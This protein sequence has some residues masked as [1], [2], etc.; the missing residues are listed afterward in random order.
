LVTVG[1]KH[2]RRG[3]VPNWEGPL[4]KLAGWL[5]RRR[6]PFPSAA[7]AQVW[8][9]WRCTGNSLPIMTGLVLPF[10]LLFLALGKNDVL[11][12]AQTL[13]S[14]LAVPV[15]LAG[16]VGVTRR[17]KNPWVK[18]ANGLAPFTAT[19]PLT[20]AALA[21]ARLK[22]AALS[23]LVAWALVVVAVPVAVLL[24]GNL[25]EVAGWWR[26]GLDRASPGQ[27]RR[28]VGG[29]RNLAAGVDVET[30]RGQPA[31]RPDGP[32]M[33][34]RL[35]PPGGLRGPDRPAC[36]G[37]V[38]LY[39][40]PATHEIALAVLP[41][42]L[43]LWML[44][45]LLAAGWVLRLVM[46]RGL[47]EARTAL[48]LADRLAAARVGA[49]RPARLECARGACGLVR[50]RAGPC[51]GACRWRGWRRRRWPWRGIGNR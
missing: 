6:R 33:G 50:S 49:D 26:Q 51:C 21:G 38:V 4:R 2:A 28:G 41:W 46:R 25:D 31:L 22:T 35:L 1:V 5:P 44:L 36:A 13:L 12:T 20:T 40:R 18:E 24:T 15:V 10:A 23:T 42:L 27:A 30:P 37:G 47:L 32:G 16:L 48:Q 9:E 45:R 7:R 11:P 29:C 19:L 8:F 39:R 17:E 34:G 43:S 3:D 14:A